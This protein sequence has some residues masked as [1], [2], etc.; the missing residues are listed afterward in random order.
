MFFSKIRLIRLKK[1][2][3][4]YSIFCFHTLYTQDIW[5]LAEEFLF[6][7]WYCLAI[8]K[9]IS[10]L[11]EGLQLF[12]FLVTKVSQMFCNI[13]VTWDN[14][15]AVDAFAEVIRGINNTGLWDA[16]LTWYSQSVTCQ[17]CLCGLKHSQKIHSINPTRHWQIVKGNFFKHLVSVLWS[18]SNIWFLYCDQLQTSGFYTVIN[19]KH[20]VTVQ[21]STSN[22]WLLYCD[23]LQ[24]SGYCTV[25][26]FKHLVTVLWSTSNIWLLYCDQLQT[27]GYCTVINFKHLVSILWSTSNIWLL[28]C[29]QLQTSGFC[30]VINFKHL[31]TVLWSTSNI[32]FLYCDQLQT[33]GFYTVINFKH[34]VIVLWSTS[35]IW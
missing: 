21:C 35:N 15:A 6:L 14:L 33:S 12:M 25:I 2:F 16:K 17:I 23:Q 9:W 28:Y 8:I 29:D 5:I 18:T 32:W 7:H 34:L 22:I 26:N 13:L 30:T 27:S 10:L 3:K 11:N 31:V 4:N 1:H 20:L 24:T 19:F